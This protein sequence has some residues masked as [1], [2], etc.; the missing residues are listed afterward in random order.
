[1]VLEISY[2]LYPRLLGSGERE[3]KDY[4]YQYSLIN[5]IELKSNL[6]HYSFMHQNKNNKHMFYKRIGIS[7][8]IW[9]E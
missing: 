2:E 7:Q 4:L 9:E 5:I 3:I 1:M 8:N 6:K